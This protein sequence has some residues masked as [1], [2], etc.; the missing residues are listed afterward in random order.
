VVQLLI[1]NVDLQFFKVRTMPLSEFGRV[2]LQQPHFLSS[3]FCVIVRLL[4]RAQI[5]EGTKNAPLGLLTS[6][7]KVL[8]NGFEGNT[9]FQYAFRTLFTFFSG[10][11]YGMCYDF[12]KQLLNVIVYISKSTDKHLCNMCMSGLEIFI[13]SF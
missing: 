7:Q 6:K 12:L 5:I 4:F 1:S 9:L 10:L 11:F 2:Q 13:P 3:P 8:K